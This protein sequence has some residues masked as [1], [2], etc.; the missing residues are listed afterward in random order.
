MAIPGARGI[1]AFLVEADTPE[2]TVD[3]PAN[4]MGQRG[5]LT[6]DVYFDSYRIPATAIIGGK[7]GLGFKTAMRVLDRGRLHISAMCVA[8][9]SRLIDEP[10]AYASDRI[11]FV[12]PIAEFQ[13]IQAMLA[14][15]R[16][17][18]LS[19]ALMVRDA[20]RRRDTSESVTLDVSYCKPF[21]LEMVGRV[22]DRAVQIH[23]GAGYIG[24]YPVE[25]FYRG[26]LLFRLYEGTSEIQKL[27]IARQMIKSV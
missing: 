12:R 18:Y 8:A 25:R 17:E 24:E 10:I 7:P 5:S 19:G 4:K 11:Q 9:A 20:A 14:E 16:T 21:R 26:V 2:P 1:S 13:L 23:G 6:A 27:I 3:R 22:A 15:G